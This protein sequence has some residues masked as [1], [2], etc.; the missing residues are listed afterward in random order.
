MKTKPWPFTIFLIALTSCQG[1]FEEET[2]EVFV[3]YTPVSQITENTLFNSVDSGDLNFTVLQE[4]TIRIDILFIPVSDNATS[5]IFVELSYPDHPSL[6]LNALGS[7]TYESVSI[8]SI[9][10]YQLPVL[11]NKVNSFLFTLEVIHPIVFTPSLSAANK[12]TWVNQSILT[13]LDSQPSSSF[14]IL[15]EGKKIILPTF[16]YTAGTV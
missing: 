15:E 2:L 13:N 4:I 11:K 16:T 12:M 8:D 9:F 5:P 1:F 10:T 3:G 7:E 14:L 6:F